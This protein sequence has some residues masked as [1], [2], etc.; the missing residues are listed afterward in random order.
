M[1]CGSC[2]KSVSN[3]S[4]IQRIVRR[5]I[6]S[7]DCPYTQSTLLD[8]LSVLKC[9][10]NKNLRATF[11]LTYQKLNLYLG[12]VQS[13]WNYSSNPCYFKT[14]LDEISTLIDIIKTNGQC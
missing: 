3:I 11:N 1:G 6:S 12:L 9:V 8:W 7:E 2:N 4:Q 13:A 10:K 14:K 5:N